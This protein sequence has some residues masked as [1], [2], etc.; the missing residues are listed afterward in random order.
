[1]LPAQRQASHTWAACRLLDERMVQI[2]QPP[3]NFLT[4]SQ[5]SP[6]ANLMQMILAN[7][8]HYSELYQ[9]KML[10]ECPKPASTLAFSQS[11]QLIRTIPYRSGVD[12]SYPERGDA[13]STTNR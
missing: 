4:R 9:T 1:L 3:A 2:S 12:A 13:L 7:V 5:T 10:S 8:R 11:Q 6:R